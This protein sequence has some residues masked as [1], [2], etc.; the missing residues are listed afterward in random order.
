MRVGML[1]YLPEVREGGQVWSGTQLLQQRV[2]CAMREQKLV[3]VRRSSSAADRERSRSFRSR[4]AKVNP[5]GFVDEDV[6]PSELAPES[7][8]STAR[9]VPTDSIAGA[10]AS[11]DAAA[12][13]PMPVASDVAPGP[14]GASEAHD[15]QQNPKATPESD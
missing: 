6:P 3:M 4:G 10:C 12:P 9:A 7:P 14:A 1:T 5:A 11:T 15:S 8:T 2:V 13:P